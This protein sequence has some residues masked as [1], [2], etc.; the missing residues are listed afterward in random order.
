MQGTKQSVSTEQWLSFRVD[1]P[2]Q[3]AGDTNLP[4]LPS[5]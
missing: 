5:I 4:H 2:Q 3:V 1:Q